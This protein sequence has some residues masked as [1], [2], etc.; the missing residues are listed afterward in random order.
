VLRGEQVA[1]HMLVYPT[2]A[3]EFELSRLEWPACAGVKVPLQHAGPQVLI[4]TEGAVTLSSPGGC[5]LR[6]ARGDSA[7][8]PAR[9]C[10]E[11][12]VLALPDDA[13]KTQVFRATAGV[14]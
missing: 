5:T 8:I 10:V 4:C 13:G 9:D 11:G 6:L 7:W 12:P 1:P 14:I 2:D 3:P